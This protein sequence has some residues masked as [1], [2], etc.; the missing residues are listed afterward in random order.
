MQNSGIGLFIFFLFNSKIFILFVEEF[1]FVS[2][3]LLNMIFF[4]DFITMFV[5]YNVHYNL[6]QRTV[7]K[8]N[9]I[10]VN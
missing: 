1:C 2:Y 5:S 7:K 6:I 8:L 10:N 9:L 3:F 4:I